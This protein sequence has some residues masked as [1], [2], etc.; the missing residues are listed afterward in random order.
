MMQVDVADTSGPVFNEKFFISVV[1]KLC[2]KLNAYNKRTH[3]EL[4]N[5][6]NH[7]QCWTLHVAFKIRE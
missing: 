2:L 4:A 5:Y 7:K 6:I 3:K 1:T